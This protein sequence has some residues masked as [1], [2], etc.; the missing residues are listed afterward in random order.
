M[1]IKMNSIIGVMVIIL[2]TII[3]IIFF[4]KGN[5]KKES[6]NDITIPIVEIQS[7]IKEVKEELYDIKN[8]SIIEMEDKNNKWFIKVLIKDT[9][10]NLENALNKLERYTV[11][12]YSLEGD[13]QIL[14]LYLE[15]YR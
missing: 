2:I 12:K 14:S 7:T 9:R 15:I 5:L 10:E 3:Q 13:N 11:E 6:K 8:L 4:L 1:R